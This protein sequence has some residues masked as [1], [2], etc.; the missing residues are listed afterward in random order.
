VDDDLTAPG[1][2][3]APDAIEV[4]ET[5]EVMAVVDVMDAPEVMGGVTVTTA[6]PEA[7]AD[8]LEVD[9]S[10]LDAIEQELEDIERTLAHLEEGTYGRCEV[11][12]DGIDD[13]VLVDAPAT[14]F[15]AAH[16]PIALG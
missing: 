10:T 6:A 13:A 8:D 16:L 1:A 2:I 15:C 3:D 11:C 4:A 5:V 7:G 14:R 12:G 9:P